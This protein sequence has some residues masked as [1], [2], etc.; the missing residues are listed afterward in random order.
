[1]APIQT[2]AGTVLPLAREAAFAELAARINAL[3]GGRPTVALSGG[4]TPKA[5]YAWAVATRALRPES[6]ERIRR[7][8]GRLELRPL[9]LE[10]WL[11]EAPATRFDRFNTI[12]RGAGRAP[13][14]LAGRPAAG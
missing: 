14:P 5:F 6:Q 12:A 7:H 11:L 1:M 9:A 10:D 2:L 8:L 3:A 13:R 4:S